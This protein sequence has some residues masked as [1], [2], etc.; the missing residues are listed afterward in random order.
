MI[1]HINKWRRQDYLFYRILSKVFRY[2]P[3]YQ[4][5]LNS[6]FPWI[7]AGLNSNQNLRKQ[8]MVTLCREPGRY[9]LNQVTKVSISC[10]DT[11]LNWVPSDN[12]QREEHSIPFVVFLTKTHHLKLFMRKHQINPCWGTVYK[13][14]IL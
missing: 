13:I 11:Y 1:R 14:T 7:W 3:Y 4:G 6:P 8:K 5:Q 12:M 9:H 2:Y 10:H